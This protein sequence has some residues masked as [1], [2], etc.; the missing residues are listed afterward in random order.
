V[1]K[2][3]TEEEFLAELEAEETYKINGSNSAGNLSR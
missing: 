3:K 2:D 1:G